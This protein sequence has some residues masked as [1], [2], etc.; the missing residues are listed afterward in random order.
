MD[1]PPIFFEVHRDLPR[2]GPGDNQ[3]TAQAFHMLKDLPAK[4]RILDIGCGPGMQTIELAKLSGGQIEAVDFH[5]PFLDELTAA[6]QKAGVSSQIHPARGDMCNLQYPKESFDLVWCEGAIF[7]I[8]FERG[9]R[10]WQ[11]LLKRGGYLVV[12]ELSWFNKADAPAELKAFLEAAYAG[13]EN[14]SANAIEENLE[15]AQKLGY[16][17]VGSFKLPSSSWWEN[18]FTPIQAKLPQLRAKHSGDPDAMAYLD[19]EERE[20]R[21]FR[22]YSDFYGYAFYLLQ[23][24]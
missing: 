16:K 19:G 13:L 11:P 8:G 5:Q 15:T 17:V 21:L 4:P 1:L 12:S 6:A 7:I 18:Y 3:S 2:E 14:S 23:K 20:A 9:L 24:T 10:E 22:R